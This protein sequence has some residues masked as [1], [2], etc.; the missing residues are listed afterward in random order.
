MLNVN[1]T[2][3]SVLLA[4][5]QMLNKVVYSPSVTFDPH[6]L[7]ITICYF[8]TAL[9]FLQLNE[10]ILGIISAKHCFCLKN[11]TSFYFIFLLTVHVHTATK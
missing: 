9:S 8:L 6:V 1:V 11:K 4:E 3:S 2:L 7:H 5:L 10:I